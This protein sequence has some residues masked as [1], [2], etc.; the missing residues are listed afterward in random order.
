M[1]SAFVTARKLAEEQREVSLRE[2]DVLLQ[3][4]LASFGAK[5]VIRQME[6]AT[7][8]QR[9]KETLTLLGT[10]LEQV[11]NIHI[12]VTSFSEVDDLLSQWRSYCPNGAGYSISFLAKDLIEQETTQG[13]SLHHAIHR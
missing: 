13:F 10:R 4:I 8:G 11:S 3:E 12:F 5:R 2:K 9:E 6:Q 1:L 7:V